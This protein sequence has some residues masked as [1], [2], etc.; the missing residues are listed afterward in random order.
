MNSGL[1]KVYILLVIIALVVSIY[2]F[3]TNRPKEKIVIKGV[4]IIQS[5]LS[6]T[7]EIT[8]EDARKVAV[9]QFKNL[10]EDVSTDQLRVTKINR[11]E[12]EFYYITSPKNSMEIRIK[13]GKIERVNSVLIEE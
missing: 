10:K 1:R 6:E 3:C 9:K 8:E 12:D 4:E 7:D 2:V 11:G 13:G 5:E